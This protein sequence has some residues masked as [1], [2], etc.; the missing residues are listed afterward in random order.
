MVYSPLLLELID[1]G[2]THLVLSPVPP[3]PPAPVRWLADEIVAPVLAEV[4]G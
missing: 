2:A 3:Y 1:A 4:T